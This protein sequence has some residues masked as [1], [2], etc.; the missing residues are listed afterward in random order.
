MNNQYPDHPP[1]WVQ[2]LIGI[3]LFAV[4]GAWFALELT[5]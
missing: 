5:K 1:V 3:S 2:Y 4:M